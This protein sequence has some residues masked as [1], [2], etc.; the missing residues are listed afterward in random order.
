MKAV[1]FIFLVST[2]TLS[3]AHDIPDLSAEAKACLNAYDEMFDVRTARAVLNG[4]VAVNT[5]ERVICDAIDEFMTVFSFRRSRCGLQF[6]VVI[7]MLKE[8]VDNIK[9]SKNVYCPYYWE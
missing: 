1:L 5:N 9:R 6:I 3:I 7:K 2:V 8:I 4:I